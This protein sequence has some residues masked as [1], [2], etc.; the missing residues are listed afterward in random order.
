MSKKK[1]MLVVDDDDEFREILDTLLK[2]QGYSVASAAGGNAA[3]EM[4]GFEYFDLILLDLEMPDS[5]GF[6][7]LRHV[8]QKHPTTKVII[9]TGYADL[10]HALDSRG[11]GADHFIGK[12]CDFSNL[13]STIQRL[14]GSA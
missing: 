11:L 4:L 10:K 1:R 7:V 6:E 14:L 13:L 2:G 8:K 3:I 12:P 5:D 9:V